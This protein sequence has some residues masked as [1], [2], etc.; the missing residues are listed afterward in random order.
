MRHVP[1]HA[2]AFLA[3][4][5]EFNERTIRDTADVETFLS[6]LLAA[7]GGRVIIDFLDAANWDYFETYEFDPKTRYLTMVWRDYRR[8]ERDRSIP[9]FF[10]ADYYA[11]FL[12]LQSIYVIGSGNIGIAMLNGYALTDKDLRKKWKGDSSEFDLRHDH[13]FESTIFRDCGEGS[14]DII[15]CHT[16]P[17]YSVAILPK[18]I[19]A[20]SWRS[21]SLLYL[22]NVDLASAKLRRALLALEAASDDDIDLICE[23]MN[24]ARRSVENVENLLKIECAY[25]ELRP[26]QGYSNL[27]I[28][29]VAG[30]LK[31]EKSAEERKILSHIERH[32][33]LYS[34]DSGVPIVR[35]EAMLTAA[36]CLA[37]SETLKSEIRIDMY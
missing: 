26:K 3:L 8:R 11:L 28:G 7:T 23:K 19:G 21:E 4:S 15:Q 1:E 27:T 6:R 18:G 32:I 25:R 9:T 37:Y 29:D 10:P 17:L 35:G 33:H 16:T 14:W 24:T 31:R 34:H 5:T 13:F 20:S 36:L 30:L 22:H 12:K 2:D